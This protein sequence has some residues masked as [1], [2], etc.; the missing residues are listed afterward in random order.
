MPSDEGAPVD[1]QFE[2]HVETSI[3][4]TNFTE[5][6]HA[7]VNEALRL[8]EG[9]FCSKS[10]PCASVNPENPENP[11][12]LGRIKGLGRIKASVLL[13]NRS[14]YSSTERCVKQQVSYISIHNK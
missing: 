12:Y 14:F 1:L 7:C 4:V 3:T 9:I 5:R 6:Y 2:T 8:N 13:R 10:I 11:D